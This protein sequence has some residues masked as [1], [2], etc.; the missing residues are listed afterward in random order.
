MRFFRV[1]L[2]VLIQT[3][4][5]NSHYAQLLPL[6]R[7][8]FDRDESKINITDNACGAVARMILRYPSAM[9]L[10]YVLPVFLSSLP[11][12]KDFQ[13]NE[14]VYKCL[15]ALLGTQNAYVIFYWLSLWKF[16]KQ[17][18]THPT[19]TIRYSY[20]GRWETSSVFLPLF[21]T[22]HWT[23]SLLEP[24]LKSRPLYRLFQR[25]TETLF[26]SSWVDSSPNK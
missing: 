17:C 9:P 11:L 14:P 26:P 13:E 22:N 2:A 16:G 4:Q 15:F 12:T 7:P 1:G 23:S 21:W 10:D 24:G 25:T 20:W 6:L 18:R 8:L 3:E 19:C 5:L